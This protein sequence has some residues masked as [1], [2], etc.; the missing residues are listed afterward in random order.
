MAQTPRTRAVRTGAIIAF[1]IFLFFLLAPGERHKVEN[2][3]TDFVQSKYRLY[4]C[5]RIFTDIDIRAWN[6]H[7]PAEPSAK[8]RE[9]HQAL[10][11]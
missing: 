10:R 7:K 3:A 8:W 5:G 11:Q 4:L 1:I 6:L 2:A 9:V